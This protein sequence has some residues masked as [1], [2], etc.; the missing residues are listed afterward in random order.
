[1]PAPI[2]VALAISVFKQ[3]PRLDGNWKDTVICHGQD[4]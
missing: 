1:M 4:H 2:S 3:V